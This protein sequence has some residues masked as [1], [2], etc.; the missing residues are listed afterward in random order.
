MYCQLKQAAFETL[1]RAQTHSR[2]GGVITDTLTRRACSSGDVDACNMV[3]VILK[4]TLPATKETLRTAVAPLTMLAARARPG[5]VCRVNADHGDTTKRALVLEERPQHRV[6]PQVVFVARHLTPSRDLPSEVR[7]V[8]DGEGIAGSEGVNGVTAYSVQSVA[9]EATFST[10]EPIPETLQASGAFGIELASDLAA[11]VPVGEPLGLHRT[12]SKHLAGGE[13]GEH[14]LPHIQPHDLATA[15]RLRGLGTD[16]DV[17]VPLAV[18][19]PD[20]LTALNTREVLPREEKPLVI[21][22][23]KRDTLSAVNGSKADGLIVHPKG[24][25]PLIV[26]YRTVLEAAGLLALT[27]CDAAYGLYRKVCGEAEPFSEIVVAQ[28]VQRKSPP[29]VVLSRHLQRVVAGVRKGRDRG[30]ECLYLTRSGLDLCFN[31]KYGIHGYYF[32]IREAVKR[33]VFIR[34]LKRAVSNPISL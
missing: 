34:P 32:I 26:G 7:Q 25:R 14:G 27:L 29:F 11:F 4:P 12:T 18:L 24:E 22:D 1:S 9:N 6:G 15:W 33:R 2:I 16:G 28:T 13:G 8:L 30:F 3:G 19:A 20:Q 31:R 10:G 5:C 21:A 23:G 17:D